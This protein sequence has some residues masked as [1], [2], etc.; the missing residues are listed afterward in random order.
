M[1]S[2]PVKEKN[3]EDN[4]LSSTNAGAK[5]GK[6]PNPVITQSNLF[7]FI[8]SSILVVLIGLPY[9]PLFAEQNFRSEK[10]F[11]KKACDDYL[12][13]IKNNIQLSKRYKCALKTRALW[14]KKP[15]AFYKK[16]CLKAS[17]QEKK[18]MFQRLNNAFYHNKEVAKNKQGNCQ[19]IDSQHVPEYDLYSKGWKNTKN[20]SFTLVPDSISKFILNAESYSAYAKNNPSRAIYSKRRKDCKLYGIA[21]NLDFN[22]STQEWLV[23]PPE[24][25]WGIRTENLDY[26]AWR[27]WIVQKDKQGKYRVLLDN[28]AGSLKIYRTETNGFK[29]IEIGRSLF[30]T[31]FK[32]SDKFRRPLKVYYKIFEDGSQGNKVLEGFQYNAKTHTYNAPYSLFCCTPSNKSCK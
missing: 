28:D 19:K 32:Q 15:L 11:T 5:F 22:Y 4:R 13:E 16:Q 14:E 27:V 18:Q 26:W 10:P 6:Y 23:V 2:S 17:N 1:N 7:L 24:D 20:P 9:T 29:D 12:V 21:L 8:V 3:H 25:C 31:R 30:Y